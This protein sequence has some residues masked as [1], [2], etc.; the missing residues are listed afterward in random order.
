MNTAAPLAPTWWERLDTLEAQTE[1]LFE[2]YSAGYAKGLTLSRAWNRGGRFYAALD[3]T[4]RFRNRG[5]FEAFRAGLL[6]GVLAVPDGE[7]SAHG[8]ES[9]AT[10]GGFLHYRMG[11]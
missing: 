8:G 11:A 2:A 4:S 5:N 7:P 9:F 1:T 10:L 3:A 6:R